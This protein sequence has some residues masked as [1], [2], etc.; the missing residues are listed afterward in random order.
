MTIR[1]QA[2]IVAGAL[3][4]AALDVVASARSQHGV[5]DPTTLAMCIATGCI[6]IAT[7]LV[8][9]RRR[10]DSRVGL[11]LCITGLL[12]LATRLDQ[13]NG[14]FLY[15]V[16][17][18]CFWLPPAVLAHILLTF[19]T[20]RIRSWTEWVLVG[21]AYLAGLVIVPSIYLFLNPQR[22]F[23]P[24]C[25]SNLV[26]VRDAPEIADGI[27]WYDTWFVI[28][29]S[30]AI[31]WVLAFRWWHATA[32]GRRVLG[33]ALWV[34][35]AMTLEFIVISFHVDW[36]LPPSRFFWVDQALTAAYPVALLLGLLRTRM[37]RAAVGDLVIELGRGTIPSGGLRDALA[38][39][40]GDPSLRLAYRLEEVDGWVDETGR[41]TD[42]PT[43]GD[44]HSAT[45]I[46][47]D[48]ESIA[49][50]IYDE[51]LVHDPERVEAVISAARLAVTN[52]RLQARVR[53]QLELVRR[54]RARVVAAADEERRRLERDLHDGAQQR[55][56]WLSLLLA[57]ADDEIASGRFADGSRS[58]DAARAE[59]DDALVELRAL[60]RG[61]HPAILTNA[62]LAPAIGSLANRSQIPVRIDAKDRGRL[63][64]AVEATAYFAIS[65]AL[66]NAAKHSRGSSAAVSLDRL[67]GHLIVDVTDDGIGGAD[68]SGSGLRGLSDRVAAA[69]GT[70]SIESPPGG[71]TS[72][73]LELPCE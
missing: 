19:P 43:A 60:A 17:L 29:I 5:F 1:T 26:L 12:F 65:E 6:Y 11:L 27:S 7:G 23:C 67:D 15:T 73:H 8:A 63:P 28:G 72:V 68:I 42:A 59:A 22:L 25:P 56:V 50:L 58:L 44:G 2:S 64:P 57:V 69:G 30:I 24:T 41:A 71:G 66:T 32:A 21:S 55:L 47:L 45:M 14:A 62:G 4:L 16:G 53:V 54:S 40:L 33:P 18:L 70:I 3:A 52:E 51:A 38:K 36:L 46:E 20:G 34:G 49:A 13:S 9:A 10:P 61:I 39:R 31:I 37:A 48:G 35:I